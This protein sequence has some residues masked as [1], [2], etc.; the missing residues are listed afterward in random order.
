MRLSDR[1]MALFRVFEER[2]SSRKIRLH[3][4]QA[5]LGDMWLC[6]VL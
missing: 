6:P 3:V 1:V 4:G 5:I 2:N